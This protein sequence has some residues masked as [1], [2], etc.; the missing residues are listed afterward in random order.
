MSARRFLP[1]EIL[2]DKKPRSA[3][4]YWTGTR[5]FVENDRGRL[6]HRPRSVTTY[7]I[8]GPRYTPHIGVHYYC[9]NAASGK[10]NFSFLDDVPSGK[11]LCIHC[12]ARAV[13]AGLPPAD[14][15]VGRHVHKGR[16][17]A[18]QT[19]C[20]ENGEERHG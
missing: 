17:V 3:V 8:P 13:M 11:L 18:K 10:R 5:P 6:I 1:L 9:G 14:E 2:E 12:E 16:I 7:R 19:C 20:S 15:L 4:V